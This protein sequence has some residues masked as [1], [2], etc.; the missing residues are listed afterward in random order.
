MCF[1]FFFF[2][3][4]LIFFFFFGGGG[5][6]VAAPYSCRLILYEV[7]LSC[8]LLAIERSQEREQR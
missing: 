5:G 7:M 4:F 1:C 2:S 8:T 6:G 3:F